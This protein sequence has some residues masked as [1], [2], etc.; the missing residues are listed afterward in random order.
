VS[1]GDTLTR[2]GV[3]PPL[4]WGASP[5]DFAL[6]T[7]EHDLVTMCAPIETLTESSVSAE[8][9][10]ERAGTRWIRPLGIV[11][12][13][14]SALALAIELRHA[15]LGETLSSVRPGFVALALGW[16]A[17]SMLA[18]AYN[19]LGFTP[20]RL[21]LGQTML[22]QIA[23]SGLRI[24]APS[25]VSTPAV[26]IRYLVRSGVRT[27]DA[28]ATVGAAQTAQLLVTTL[29]VSVLGIAS[30]D[31]AGGAHVN[32]TSLLVGGVVVAL[33]LTLFA[34]IARSYERVRDIVAQ[35]GRSIAT[36]GRH[37]RRRP[38]MVGVGVLAS[39]ALT[40][41]HI[42]AFAACVSA[43]GG[44]V[45]LLALATIYL[46]AAAAGSIVPTPGGLGAVEAALIAGLTTAGLALPAATG[47][48]LLSRF[49]AV[50]LPSIPGWIAVIALR[51]RSLL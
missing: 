1:T 47:A 5:T 39:G 32:I 4:I 19:L 22:V 8:A 11:L 29:L 26:T 33:V 20:V 28:L 7:R 38:A 51:R 21:R 46:A 27:P 15:H 35:A 14:A 50:W 23:T 36:L 40:V 12:A 10:D 31:T 6:G 41:A 42:L 18:A 13:V 17:L 45:S 16:T 30:G 44:Q 25:A 9:H 2:V 43:V 34:A 3:S 37:L 49:V 48:A 24:I